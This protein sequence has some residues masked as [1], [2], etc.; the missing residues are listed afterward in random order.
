MIPRLKPCWRSEL[1][2]IL[3][4]EQNNGLLNELEKQFADWHG[5]EFACFF[6]YARMGFF[7]LLKALQLKNNQILMPAYTCVVMAN[8]AVLAGFQPRFIDVDGRAL[9]PPEQIIDLGNAD[10]YLLLFTDLFGNELSRD[11]KKSVLEWANLNS[12]VVVEDK[13]MNLSPAPECRTERGTA[14]IFSFMLNKQIST[15]FGGMVCTD[16]LEVKKGTTRGSRPPFQPALTTATFE[17][18][19]AVP[20]AIFWLFSPN[21]PPRALVAKKSTAAATPGPLL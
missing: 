18:T 13:A 3:C 21:L 4:H 20:I 9:M 17:P 19:T 16:S 12:I 1:I 7:A 6:P 10:A 8:A 5:T 15:I 2:A 11:V 14:Q